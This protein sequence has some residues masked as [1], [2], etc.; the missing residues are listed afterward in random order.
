MKTTRGL[1]LTALVLMT[2]ACEDVPTF[3]ALEIEPSEASVETA[4]DLLK[5]LD[6]YL[7]R[8]EAG[9]LT[10]VAKG[11]I[12]QHRENLGA[13]FRIAV[14]DHLWSEAARLGETIIA[15]FPN[16]QM[17]AEVRSM[18]DVLRTRGGQPAVATDEN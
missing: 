13:A 10:E 7:G 16:T 14:N 4:M 2:A 11:V 9:R 17:A 8:D 12:M 18:I 1:T 5:Q 15:E 6:L 3:P